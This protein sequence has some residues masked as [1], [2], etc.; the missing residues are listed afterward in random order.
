M[1]TKAER[2][3]S[4]GQGSGGNGRRRKKAAR[5]STKA[6]PLV[7]ELAPYEPRTRRKDHLLQLISPPSRRHQ[8]I[9]GSSGSR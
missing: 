7:F 2:R 8:S 6:T 5:A 4:N 9:R 3:R 1:A